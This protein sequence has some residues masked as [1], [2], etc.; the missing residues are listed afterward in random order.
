MKGRQVLHD[1]EK[2]TKDDTEV[3]ISKL[4]DKTLLD[5]HK[6]THTWWNAIRPGNEGRKEEIF[7][8]H[9][10]IAHELEKRNIGHYTKLMLSNYNKNKIDGELSINVKVIDVHEVRGTKEKIYLTAI[11]S[12]EKSIPIGRTYNSDVIADIGDNIRVELIEL[13]KYIDPDTREVWYDFWSPRVVEKVNSLDSTAEADE[14]VK[15]TGGQIDMKKLPE[16][17]KGILD[18][19]N[20]FD[21]FKKNALL[22]DSEEFDFALSNNWI[23]G[24]MIPETLCRA[25]A[26]IRNEQNYLIKKEL[27]GRVMI[28]LRDEK[29]SIKIQKIINLVEV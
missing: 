12:G 23:K 20:Y 14:L 7:N 27:G 29:N 8:A 24:S 10:L 6:I 28:C 15:K 22:W 25:A 5:N 11:Q 4:S 3:D 26:E 1:P 16:R 9:K 2:V 18:E 13:S 19:E 21:I 17:Y